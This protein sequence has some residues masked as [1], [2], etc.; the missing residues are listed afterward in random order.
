MSLPVD[1]KRKSHPVSMN[2]AEWERC[3]KG[4]E[5]WARQ[6]GK[7]PT[8]HV[9]STSAFIREAALKAADKMEAEATLKAKA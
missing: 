1:D 6:H 8:G 3:V 7:R 9:V 2:R 4:A 5:A